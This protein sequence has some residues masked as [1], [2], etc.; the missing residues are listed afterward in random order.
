MRLLLALSPKLQSIRIFNA[1]PSI[2]GLIA[3]PA[4]L[5]DTRYTPPCSLLKFGLCL[6]QHEY[7]LITSIWKLPI[8]MLWH[9]KI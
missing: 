6:E 7:L 2:L 8:A 3:K 9:D 5:P 4:Q 1:V